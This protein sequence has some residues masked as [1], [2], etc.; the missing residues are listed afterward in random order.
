MR[1]ELFVLGS[2]FAVRVRRLFCATLAVG[3]AVT[4]AGA[5]EKSF[6]L[7][8]GDRVLFMGDTFFERE[9]DYGHIETRLTAAFPDRRIKRAW[10][11]FSQA[12]HPTLSPSEG[13]RESVCQ[14][15]GYWAVNSRNFA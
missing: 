10:K 3:L 2:A 14:R 5:V 4:G 1:M 13:E 15:R 11:S 12:P 8:D 9:V 7:K 6:E